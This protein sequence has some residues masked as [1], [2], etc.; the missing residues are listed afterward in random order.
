MCDNKD[1][2]KDAI[3]KVW[4]HRRLTLDSYFCSDKCCIEYARR[5]GWKYSKKNNQ[6]YK[7]NSS[8]KQIINL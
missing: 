6:L 8:K 7:P 5:I 4:L 1:C 3:F 2:T